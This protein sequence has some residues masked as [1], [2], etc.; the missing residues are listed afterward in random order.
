[1]S[2]EKYLI[3]RFLV[4]R[5]KQH[6]RRNV[7]HTNAVDSNIYFDQHCHSYNTCTMYR[8]VAKCFII[9]SD[10]LV[11]MSSVKRNI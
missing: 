5:A 10:T 6:V 2:I 11:V 8:P 7:K 1:M 4:K 9:E 3:I